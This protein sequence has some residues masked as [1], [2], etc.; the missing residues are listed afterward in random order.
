MFRHQRHD[1]MEPL[2]PV[3]MQKLWMPICFG[4][5]HISTAPVFH[6]GEIDLFVRVEVGTKRSSF[7]S[8]LLCKP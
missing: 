8:A 7:S 3:V 6:K 5:S 4:R 2:R 1:D